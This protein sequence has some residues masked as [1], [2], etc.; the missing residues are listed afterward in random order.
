M[1]AALTG[2]GLSAGAGLNAFIPLVIVGIFARFT[3]FIELP[4]HLAWL[5]SWPAI[6]ICLALLAAELVLDKIPGVDHVNDLIQSAVR[7]VVGGVIFAATSAAEVQD[8]STFWQENPL[9]GGILGAV[10]TGIGDRE[11]HLWFVAIAA[12]ELHTAPQPLIAA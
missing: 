9:L 1:L 10:I 7:P 3:S 2:A 6:I 8:Q 5:E 4:T 11:Q 12:G